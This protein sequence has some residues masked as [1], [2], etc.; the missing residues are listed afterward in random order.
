M[1]IRIISA[2]LC[3]CPLPALA[4]D[5]SRFLKFFQTVSGVETGYYIQ[6]AQPGTDKTS[7][8]F[9]PASVSKIFTA[10]VALEQLGENM[11]IETPVRWSTLV[12]DPSVITNVT[13]YGTGDPSWGAAEFQETLTSRF[14]ELGEYFRSIGVRRIVGPL[15]F[16]SSRTDLERRKRKQFPSTGWLDRDLG[17]CFGLGAVPGAFNQRMNCMKITFPRSAKIKQLTTPAGEAFTLRVNAALS[18]PEGPGRE[19]Y[20][21]DDR[22]ELRIEGVLEAGSTQTMNVALP[23]EYTISWLARSL[24]SALAIKAIAYTLDTTTIPSDATWTPGS[25]TLYSPPLSTLLT[26]LLKNSVNL[27]GESV[28]I[29]IGLRQST[30]DPYT[31]AQ[32]LVESTVRSVAGTG[33]GTV[34]L[35][36]GCGLSR[37][38]LISPLATWRFLEMIRNSRFFD[39]IRQMLPIAGM[40][41]STLSSRFASN[42]R[43]RGKLFAKTGSLNYV[44]NLAGF[45][46][47]SGDWLSFAVFARSTEKASPT[48]VVDR[49]VTQF[50]VDNPL[51]RTP[52]PRSGVRARAAADLRDRATEW[53]GELKQ[54]QSLIAPQENGEYFD[55]LRHGI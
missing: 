4:N 47:T 15:N 28:L 49:V 26:E 30:E 20:W 43:L 39:Q 38:N 53:M 1:R 12:S 14:E 40:P 55:E 36:D 18:G 10:Y 44:S 31:Y 13:I 25:Y 41:G 2:I 37:D 33:A 7:D 48:T 8:L 32:R 42:T 5:L 52:A 9:A 50:G 22:S 17:A 11:R 54:P 6:G 46:Q 27:I 19:A 23:E 24:E 16:V 21:S 3:L 45:I 34:R 35:D 51:R 29:Q